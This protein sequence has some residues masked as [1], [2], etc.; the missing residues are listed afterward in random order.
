[1]K[2]S[3]SSA[4][5]N[6]GG[7]P[8]EF[9]SLSFSAATT[10]ELAIVKYAGPA[11]L[12]MKYVNFGSS[13]AVPTEYVTNSSTVFG[14]ANAVGAVAVAA[15]PW[16]NTPVFNTNITRPVVEPF[17]SQGGTPVFITKEGVEVV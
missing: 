14:H 9:I 10:I 4:R 13:T 8:Y 7:D 12:L 1:V 17:S 5:D 2:E 11:P 6:I 15:S 3:L 16:Y